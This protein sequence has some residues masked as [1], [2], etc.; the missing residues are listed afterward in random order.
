MRWA[1]GGVFAETLVHREAERL[2]RADLALLQAIVYGTLRQL[3]WLN[4]LCDRL[5]SAPLESDLRWLVTSAL[6]QLFLLDLP[7]YAVVNETVRCAPRRAHGLVNAMLRAAGR[8]RDELLAERGTLPPPVRYSTPAWL[9]ERWLR[10]FGAE[11]TEAMLAWNLGT[12]PLY[13]RLNPLRPMAEIPADWEAVEGA[14]R[15]YR[16][17]P[18]LPE[19]ELHAGR[20]YVAD[21]STRHSVRLLAPKPGERIL[22]ACAAPGG[23]SAAL[24]GE[25][26][27]DLR[28]LATD[29]DEHRLAPLRDNLLRAGGRDVTVEAHDWT[30]A[31]PEEWKG[32]FDAVLL[33]APCSNTGVFQRRVDARWRL[34]ESE[35]DRLA[36]LQGRLLDTACDAV[37]P[38]GRLVYSTCSID[39]QEDRDA[40]DAF[41]ARRPD[42][43]LEEDYLA[44]PH[45]ERADGAYAA[46]LRRVS[47]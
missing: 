2:S 25:T 1:Q 43:R 5:R 24:I 38:G 17:P 14:P 19:Q 28:L 15:W 18:G 13:A 31:C 45:R 42:F 35:F 46:R 44:L 26:L 47:C 20:I 27:G 37:A 32:A 8:Q 34:K 41:L 11:E 12:P 3:T 23:K 29:L 30:Q 6:C 4:H 21:P 33:D 36:A 9:V 7:D 16:L 40:V 10:E 39:R 22:D